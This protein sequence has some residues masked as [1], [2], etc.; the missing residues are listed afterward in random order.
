MVVTLCGLPHISFLCVFD[1][2][3]SA[4]TPPPFPPSSLM[5]SSSDFLRRTSYNQSDRPLWPIIL[6][7]FR[8]FPNLCSLYVYA[9]TRSKASIN[10]PPLLPTPASPSSSHPQAVCEGID[11]S[12]IFCLSLLWV[13]DH[14]HTSSMFSTHLVYSLRSSPVDQL[15]ISFHLSVWERL[16]CVYLR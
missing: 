7:V 13:F 12:S 4:S 1:E 16:L 14:P 9:T 10:L 15:F 6:I 3:T 2:C 5:L 11:R 8:D